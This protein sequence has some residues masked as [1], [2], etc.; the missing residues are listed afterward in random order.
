MTI[1]KW[2]P[3]D[4]SITEGGE[5]KGR[6]ISRKWGFPSRTNPNASY[7]CLAFVDG[8]IT[9]NCPGWT[10][11]CKNGIRECK[12]T[13]IVENVLLALQDTE[14]NT[15]TEVRR[16]GLTKARENVRRRFNFSE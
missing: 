15:L 10:R 6:E 3:G 8:S 16:T 14:L 13:Q 1:Q 5:Y 7:E 11:R 9:C 4:I 2:Q 12:H